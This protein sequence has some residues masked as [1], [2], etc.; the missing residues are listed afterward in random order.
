MWS[1][2]DYFSTDLRIN[3]LDVGAALTEEPTY[4][5]LLAA[6]RARIT[7]FEP[8]REACDR[9][10]REYGEPHR[11]HPYFIGDGR[12]A[13]FH[14]TNWGPTGSLYAPNTPLLEKFQ[15]LAEVATLIATHPIN[16][17]RLDDLDEITDVDFFKIDVQGSELSVFQNAMRVLADTLLIQTEVAFVE[18][19]LG[20]P[21]FADVDVFLRGAGFKFHGLKTMGGRRFKPP[22]GNTDIDQTFSQWLW[23]DA[24]YVRDW[25]KLD[26]LE[27][28][29][30][31]KYAVLA[32]DSVRAFDLAHLVLVALDTKTGGNLAAQY[33]VRLN[34]EMDGPRKS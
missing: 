9:L 20:G 19:Y 21:L 17:T 14:E 32:H 13:I 11:F 25:M 4:Q 5:S 12:H 18:G 27:V 3:I 15:N 1:L 6:G 10:N 23:A 29:K 22:T 30:L 2:L 33:L 31:Q 28:T 26:R 34:D 8:D 16:T 7:G 24:L